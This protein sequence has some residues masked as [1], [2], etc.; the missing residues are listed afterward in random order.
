MTAFDRFD[1]FERRIT[2]AIDD[3]ALARRPDY[4]DD[5]LQ[6]TARSAQRPRWT[7]R[8][9]RRPVSR[10]AYVG[11]T[12]TVLAVLV[13]G[14]LLLRSSPNV[15][16]LPTAPTPSLSP[17]PTAPEGASATATLPYA[18]RATWV[19]HAGP[20]ASL[21]G[22]SSTV[23]LVVSSKGDRLSIFEAGVE[24]FVSREADSPTTELDLISIDTAGGCQIGDLGRY[25]FAYGTD[26]GLPEQAHG[27]YLQFNL[28]P[29]GGR[30][31][32]GVEDECAARGAA[33]L[34]NWVYALDAGND[35]GRGIVTTLSPMFLITLPQAAYG[36]GNST[37]WLALTSSDRQFQAY[38]NPIGWTDPCSATGG[39]ERP[40]DP[41]IA[42]FTAYLRTL[43]GLTVQTSA[44]RID[45]LSARLV[46]IE[47]TQT[48]DCPT[49]LV[50]AWAGPGS[51][52]EGP[53]KP[54]S[55]G[56]V[57]RQGDT[58]VAYVVEVDGGL[59]VFQWLGDGVT[60]EEEQALLATIKFTDTLPQ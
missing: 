35:G 48:A 34:R 54:Y 30:G 10:L 31:S 40:I 38:R 12:V 28:V 4:L 55:F 39:S 13:G 24:K 43:P 3:I 27:T 56:S 6:L 45:G 42:A 8:E 11:A 41:T 58:H 9:W 52:G 50:Y 16:P 5:I 57:L 20:A 29:S 14:I 47:S 25:T 7:F 32:P 15:G 46:A 33:L 1:P 17:S 21:G 2:E 19:A 36:A 59:F 23:R 60:R 37:D 49:H 51:R 26:A 53:V 18:L 22:T 44:L